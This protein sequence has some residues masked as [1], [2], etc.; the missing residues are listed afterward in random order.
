MFLIKKMKISILI[1]MSL[2]FCFN[3]CSSRE[4]HMSGYNNMEG[5]PK[6]GNMDSLHM[7]DSQMMHM[8]K[9][10][11]IMNTTMNTMMKEKDPKKRRELCKQHIGQIQGHM[12]RVQGMMG[13]MGQMMNN[14]FR[15]CVRQ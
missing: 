7:M 15:L 12:A 6:I 4:H 11:N 14:D 8:N 1:F 10:M 3:A 9:E 13:Q 2:L 5:R